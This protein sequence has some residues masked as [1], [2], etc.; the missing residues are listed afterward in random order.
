MDIDEDGMVTYRG[1]I[2]PYIEHAMDAASK[3]FDLL[4]SEWAVLDPEIESSIEGNETWFGVKDVR[5]MMK[6]RVKAFDKVKKECNLA[7]C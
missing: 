4:A 5:A 6:N 7:I 2:Y 1:A 3:E